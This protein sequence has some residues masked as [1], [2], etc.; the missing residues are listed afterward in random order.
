MKKAAPTLVLRNDDHE[1]LTSY[2]SS[3]EL[4]GNHSIEALQAELKKAKLVSKEEFPEDA[5]RLNSRVKVKDANNGK[6]MELMVV[7]PDDADIKQRKISVTAPVGIALIGFRKGQKVGWQ[8]P[9]G[10]KTFTITDVV[11]QD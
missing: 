10:M 8:V 6:E 2:L 11:N 7:M 1:I 9:A 4:S 5:I 3:Q